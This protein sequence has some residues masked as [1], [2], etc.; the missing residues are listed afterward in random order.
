MRLLPT[1]Y[2]VIALTIIIVP[3]TLSP[4]CLL[5]LVLL[6]VYIANLCVFYFYW[7]IGKLIAFFAASGVHLAQFTSGYFHSRRAAFFSQLKA[8]VGH[9]IAKAAF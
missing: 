1:K 6:G 2:A 7:L 3:L 9:A 4:L 8:K 5:L